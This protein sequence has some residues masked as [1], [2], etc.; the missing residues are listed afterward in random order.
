MPTSA[1]YLMDDRRTDEKINDEIVNKRANPLD[2]K[3]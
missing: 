1:I 2:K 3:F